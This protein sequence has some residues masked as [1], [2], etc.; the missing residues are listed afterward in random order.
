MPLHYAASTDNGSIIKLLLD[1]G[2]EKDTDGDGPDATPLYLAAK[3]GLETAIKVLWTAEITK[4]RSMKSINWTIAVSR[5]Y[6][7]LRIWE[8]RRS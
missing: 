2:A 3:Q 6:I 8:I 7:K 5:H 4:P 1:C